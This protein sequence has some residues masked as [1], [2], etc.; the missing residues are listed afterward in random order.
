MEFDWSPEEE[1]FREERRSFSMS[2]PGVVAAPGRHR[3]MASVAICTVLAVV[4]SGQAPQPVTQR[5]S[6]S[7][8]SRRMSSALISSARYSLTR[9]SA[10]SVGKAVGWPRK[11]PGRAGPP[12][13]KMVGRSRRAAP[14]QWP[15]TIL[16]QVPMQTR[17]RAL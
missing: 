1:A 4:S 13:R 9:V 15:G 10:T 12:G 2:L 5:P 17:P 11:L 7:W 16:S 8:S 14:S 6:I 3:P